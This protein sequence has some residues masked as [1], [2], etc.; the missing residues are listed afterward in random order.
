[1]KDN[2]KDFGAG[3]AMLISKGNLTRQE[4][5]E[6]FDQL[7]ANTQPD[8]QQGAFLAA[9]TAKG[10]TAEEIAG[11]W[12]SIYE[13]DT[14]RV[15]L[16]TPRPII[17]NSGTGMDSLKTF[18]VSTAAAVIAA[19]GGNY[20]ARHG[21]R[22][23]TSTCGTID[24]CEALGVDVECDIDVVK[25]SIE[26]T[27]IGVF[28]GMSAKV[29]PQALFRI[30]SQIRF[31]TT[32]N[33][34]ASLSNPALPR[35]GVRGV[36]T[37]SLV[38]P[39]ARVMREIGYKRALVFHG[40]NGCGRGM[41]EVSIFGETYVAELLD[42][43]EIVTYTIT[44]E[45]FGVDSA[46]ESDVYPLQDRQAEARRLVEILAGI[47]TTSDYQ[48]VCANAA[49]IFCVGGQVNDIA[50]GYRLAQDIVLSGKAIKKLR[51]WVAS[52]NTEPES[53]LGRLDEI[54]SSIQTVKSKS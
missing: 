16:K 54:I 20:M 24:I 13:G 14:V 37:R 42:T 46:P 28:N 38:E 51:D 8:L 49:P 18:N 29:H 48:M 33:I 41:D 27:G 19:A 23:L 10:E 45:V 17:D 1:L 32:L 31:G 11:A 2:L 3:V 35:H 22:A 34:S 44:P 53:G 25:Q 21:A 52:Q 43:S 40:S 7:M 50:Q 5:K 26:A 30:L 47:R 15:S 9:L 6:M 39:V 12:Q 4:T 36:Y